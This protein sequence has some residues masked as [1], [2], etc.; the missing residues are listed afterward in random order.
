VNAGFDWRFLDGW[1]LSASAWHTSVTNLINVTANGVPNPDQPVTFGYENVADAYTQGVELNARIRLL[2]SAWLDLGYMGLD[3]RDL[4]RNR[5][6]EGRANHRL[7][8]TLTGKY[9]PAGLDAV[10]RMTFHGERP[11]YS[12]SGLGFANVLGFEETTLIAPAYV[13]L[14]AQINWAIRPW[15][16]VF[17]NAYNLLNQ[18]DQNFNP[19]PPRGILGGVT[20]EY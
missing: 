12:G 14:E 3:A 19:R 18:G 1:V 11:Y 5:P 2:R 9:R 7:N 13:D 16:K 8:A 15:I 10:V 4:T 17:V 6:L 20:L